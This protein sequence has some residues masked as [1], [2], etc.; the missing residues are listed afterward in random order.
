[1]IDVPAGDLKLAVPDGS[2]RPP[3]GGR[4]ARHRTEGP[5]MGRMVPRIGVAA[6]RPPCH[7]R[8]TRLRR[9]SANARHAAGAARTR[10]VAL[11]RVDRKTDARLDRAT[12]R[13]A[14][15]VNGF[16]P[17]ATRSAAPA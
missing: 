3:L 13:S 17:H 8:V 7:R 11:R 15:A 4:L 6:S 5:R 14:S 1:M 10:H 12:H 9:S 2:A 16:T